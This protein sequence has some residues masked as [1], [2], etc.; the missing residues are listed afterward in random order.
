MLA[1]VRAGVFP[2]AASGGG[3]ETGV[4]RHRT[5]GG[6]KNPEAVIQDNGCHGPAGVDQRVPLHGV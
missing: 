5:R 1:H 3:T 2:R 6:F 4:M